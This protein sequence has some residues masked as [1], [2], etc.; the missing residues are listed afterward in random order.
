MGNG[1]SQQW[2]AGHMG[3][4]SADQQK[5]RVTV[6]ETAPHPGTTPN[7]TVEPFNDVIG[8]DARPVFTREIT[9]L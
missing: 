5:D 8:A 2:S 4:A 9:V 3:Q 1:V 6:R 7:F